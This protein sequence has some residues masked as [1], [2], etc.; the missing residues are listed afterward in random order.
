MRLCKTLLVLLCLVICCLQMTDFTCVAV[1]ERSSWLT[2]AHDGCAVVTKLLVM[3]SISSTVCHSVC[4][5]TSE[6]PPPD[7]RSLSRLERSDGLFSPAGTRA[8][9]L[10]MK[11]RML[12]RMLRNR[13]MENGCLQITL[14][15]EKSFQF[16]PRTT[17]FLTW[18]L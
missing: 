17:R 11:M 2:F 1:F 16:C 4:H 15:L 6:L 10:D 13:V 18:E 5:S 14:A 8:Q 9:R 12:V 7:L 3:A